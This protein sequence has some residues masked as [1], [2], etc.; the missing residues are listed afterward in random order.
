[1]SGR[2]VD[3]KDRLPLSVCLGFGVGTV[4][5]SIMLNGVTAYFPAYMSTVLGKS[6]AIAGY[7]L[8]ASK[9]YDAFADV[10]IGMVSDRTRSRWGRRRPYLLFGAVLSA[11]SFLMIFT[12]PAIDDATVPYYM[13]AALVLYSTGYS[14][15]NVPY[16]A[17]PSEMTASRYERSRLLSFRTLFVSIGQLL[18]IAGTA[19][20]ISWGGG[21]AHGYAIMAYV[22]G[23][24]IVSAMVA[25]FFGTAKAP[26]LEVRARPET[27]LD[28][29]QIALLWRNRPFV[30]LL[31][32]KV[33]QFL[34]FA[35]V[36]TTQ[37]LFMLNVLGIG[38][39]G[40]MQLAITQNVVVAASMPVWLAL[41]RRM[42]KRNAYLIGIACMCLYSISWIVA[43]RSLGI[44]GLVVRGLL[45]GFGSGGMIL[46]SISMLADTLA[47]DRELTGLHREGLLSSVA[48]VIE[49]T[50]FALGVA[51]VGIFLS[52]AHYIPTKNGQIVAQ[53]GSAISALYTCFSLLP[54]VLFAAN[55]AC[56][57]FY[58][59][60]GRA[61]APLPSHDLAA[62]AL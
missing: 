39:L 11:A 43:D 25:S 17:M 57:W 45:G 58:T 22:M 50:A 23:L 21:G 55:A 32:A 56:I 28:K 44:A 20:L 62:D 36:A 1:M 18:A 48:A 35:S 40:Q 27:Q 8:M 59:L 13:F 53:P 46:L 29:S 61:A 38:Y 60:G 12:P 14:L 41:E 47:Y 15:F 7:L 10:V 16:M 31:S 54:V 34:S 37:L 4:G 30:L 51:V 33:F 3:M 24:V 6:T 2:G 9:L 49:K 5:V 52:A 42:G 19:S 26:H